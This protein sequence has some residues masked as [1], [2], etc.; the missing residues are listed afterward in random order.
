ML[1]PGWRHAA[2]GAEAGTEVLGRGERFAR[3][4]QMELCSMSRGQK[5][6]RT[7]PRTSL[8]ASVHASGIN[9]F[10]RGQVKTEESIMLSI[11]R[12]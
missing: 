4:R 3:G 8:A 9:M 10:G 5:I 11:I 1:D 7:G 6:E 2:G 12:K